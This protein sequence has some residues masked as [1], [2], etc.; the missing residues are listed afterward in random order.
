MTMGRPYQIEM[1]VLSSRPVYYYVL[2]LTALC[3]T[4]F[5]FNVDVKNCIKHRGPE[6][7]MFGF[8]VAQHKEHGRSWLLIGA[9]EAQTTQPGVEKG[10]AVFRCGTSREDFCEKILFD[11]RGNN[12]STELMI[13]ID[14]KSR[15]WFGATVRSSGDDGVILA[16]APRYVY[17]STGGNRK[18]PVG[19][20]YVTR[21]F[22]DYSEY[23]P[24]R[25]RNWGHHKQGTCQAGLGASAS[26][27]GKRLFIG[28]VGSWYWQGQLYS[29]NS[30][31]QLPFTPATQYIFNYIDEGQVYSQNLYSRPEVFSTNEGPQTD[32]DSYLGYSVAVGAFG[33]G[34]ESGVAVGMPRGAELFGKIVLYS[35]NLTNLYNITGEQIGGYFGYSICVSDV[36]GDGGDDIIV[37]APMYNDYSKHDESYET[38]KVYVYL[39][40]DDYQFYKKNTIMGFNSKS[41]F[42][43]ALTSLGD[44]NLDGYGDFAV[45]APYDGP[46]ELGAVYIYLGTRKGVREKYSQ[47]I[48]S[49]DVSI[50]QRVSTFGFSL[51]G[52]TDLDNNQY[53]DLII[54]AYESDTAYFMRSRPVAQMSTSVSFLSDNKKISL[55]NRK[56]TTKDGTQVPCLFLKI[57]L[58][59]TGIGV[60]DQ[61]DIE[62][63]LVLDAKK[64]KF[65]RM[66]FL[67]EENQN[68]LNHSYITLDKNI[69]WCKQLN[70]Y[71]KNNIKDKLTP[72]EAELWYTIREENRLF[73]TTLTPILD[74]ENE[75][76]AVSKDSI[77]IQKNCGID[78]IC[79]P[80]LQI[81]TP[82][83]K[84]YLLGSNEKLKIDV[85]VQN[86]GE[87]SFETTFDMTV[88][89]GVNYVKIEK[90]DDSEKDIP[91]QC[92]APSSMTNNT[93]H[94]DIGNPLPGNKSVQF[95]VVFE[96]YTT[97]ETKDRYEFFMIVNSTNPETLSSTSNNIHT[98]KI[99]LWVETDLIIEGSSKPVDVHYNITMEES[100]NITDE[101]QIGPQV[102]HIYGIRNKGPSDIL[103]TEAYIDWPLFTL[104][105]EPL[106]YLLEMPETN[107]QVKCEALEEINPLKLNID[108]KKKTYFE[109]SGLFS[110]GSGLSGNAKG[111]GSSLSSS[112]IITGTKTFTEL[113]EEEKRRFLDIQ[114]KHEEDSKLNWGHGL[115][116]Q[117]IRYTN[118]KTE[119]TGFIEEGGKSTENNEASGTSIV[120]VNQGPT[121]IV[122]SSENVGLIKNEYGTRGSSSLDS[123][124]Y[125]G[126]SSHS[127]E[128]SGSTSNAGGHRVQ[129]GSGSST[130]VHKEDIQGSIEYSSSRGVYG[131][132]HFDET[133]SD[134]SHFGSARPSIQE[135]S[136][137]TVVGTSHHFGT[138][139]S[140]Q[141][142]SSGGTFASTK[143]NE[144]GSRSR[145]EESSGNVA[146]TS[147]FGAGYADS[148]QGSSTHRE[149]S[150]NIENKSRFG[151]NWEAQGSGS[152]V[153][154]ESSAGNIAESISNSG[155][156]GYDSHGWSSNHHIRN[157]NTTHVENGLLDYHDAISKINTGTVTKVLSSIPGDDSD[158]SMNLQNTVTERTGQGFKQVKVD[159]SETVY[160]W[161]TVD[162]KL[163]KVKNVD[164]WKSLIS[165]DISTEVYEAQD[166]SP[167]DLRKPISSEDIDGK[168]KLYKRFKRDIETKQCRPTHCAT[169]KCK[170]GPLSKDQEVW[171]SFRSRAWVNTLKKVFRRYLKT[172][173][174][175]NLKIN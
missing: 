144:A 57:C 40:K 102:I 119:T 117:N 9:P 152:S 126:S 86:L 143:H 156:A 135:S 70:V 72:L 168:F 20:C 120:N 21:N 76:F 162:G 133:E 138:E 174:L 14:S 3:C 71:L 158:L 25:T 80:D 68:V 84:T 159:E 33:F 115:H 132:A 13:Q 124:V 23:S 136:R 107:G 134:K 101:K 1:T 28:A 170:I 39:K 147:Y 47:V 44:I 95:R 4:V 88:P 169:I 166:Y 19:T 97:T 31:A 6:G 65:P 173:H 51:S 73:T 29:V 74:L 167:Q 87:D 32:D 82:T 110:S 26:K 10:G 48:K 140:T 91:V 7:S 34:S 2:L 127:S 27:D 17:Y 41:R 8:S 160:K 157:G 150:V 78:N 43:L 155:S 130:A 139:S 148:S 15:Q 50:G 118:S 129:G 121:F 38:G 111:D 149:S 165:Q 18:D 116:E 153:T 45:G 35:T 145:N 59:Y 16:C 100:L 5:G 114:K 109:S 22:N 81:F 90:L 11:K 61:L 164:D 104:A 141:R 161:K 42:G 56:C 108:R 53:P 52:G 69:P 93:L 123:S 171:L 58:Q 105:G 89:L 36:D 55:E 106:L 151:T 137:G 146:G 54:G 142:E 75:L 30:T 49:E 99:P 66:F 92:S 12:N 24:C 62:M 77:S 85:K 163:Y 63:R 125:M 112:E 60:D 67:M 175:I 96:P 64:L 83:S 172:M 128:K 79:I 98:L 122:G 131:A 103:E 37:G 113:T 154:G 94:C 46:G